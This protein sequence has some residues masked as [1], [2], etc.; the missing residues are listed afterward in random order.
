MRRL[1][2]FI[3]G[4]LLA[5]L[6][7]W[8]L[9]Y[10]MGWLMRP[11]LSESVAP[12]SPEE[13]KAAEENRR[14]RIDPQRPLVLWRDVD[15]SQ[16]PSAPWYPKGEAPVLRELVAEGKLPPVHERVGP[17][18]LVLAGV[19]GIGRYGG[20]W[21]RVA[22]ADGD[23]S[24]VTS[25]IAYPNLVRWSPQGYP[26]VPHIAKSFEAS[27]DK[28][29]YVFTLRRGM[30]WSDG[31]PFTTDDIMYWWQCEATYKP[32]RTVPPTIMKVRGELGQIEKIDQYRFRVK[33]PHPNGLFLA[34]LAT[35]A[36]AEFTNS[37]AHYLRQYHPDFGDQALIEKTMA[38]LKLQTKRA[39][40][41]A[42]R[43]WQNPEH[44]RLWPWL[45]RTYKPNPPHTLVRNPYYF[46]V[47]SEGNQLP[48]VDRLLFEVKTPELIS[49]SA[50]N[51]EITMQ[52]RHIRYS[53]YTLLMSNRRAGGYEVLHWYSGDRSA[54]VI[55]PNLQRKVDPD[56]PS[57]AKKRQLLNMKEFRQALSL[58]ID[59]PSLILAEYNGQ[60]E[61]SQVAPGPESPFHEP[62][63]YTAYTAY[64]PDRAN[65]LLDS[66][67]LSRRDYEG[68]RT[69]PDGTRMQFYI[70]CTSFTGAQ[71]AQAVAEDW[72]KVGIRCAVRERARPLYT[73]YVEAL[74]HDFCV[75]MS[76]GEFMPLLE[77]R[78]YVPVLGSEYARGFAKWYLW[79]G[80]YGDPAARNPGA[81]EP[82]V[83]HPLRR[84][85]EIYE[86]AIAAP[87]LEKQVE[88]FREAMK[89]AAENVWTINICTAPPTLVIVKNGFRNVPRH[90]VYSW[91]FQS[92]GN[93]GVETYFFES[94]SDSP[95]AVAQVKHDVM[96]AT[97]RQA[98][99]T[100]AKPAPSVSRPIWGRII[101]TLIWVAVIAFTGFLAVRHPYIGR[102]L[103]IMVPTLLIISIIAFAIIQLP[104]GDYLTTRIARLQESGD[105]ADLQQIEE[106]KELFHLEDPL[107]KQYLRWSG[108]LWFSTFSEKDL[109]LLQGYMGRSM[110]NSQPVNE[111]V[112]DRILLTVILSLGTVLLTWAIALPIGIYSAVRQYS[113]GDYLATF[114]GFIGMC[115]PNFLL[116]LV[117]MYIASRFFGIKVSGL[118]SSHYGAQ[119]EW[120]WGKF[121]D[122]LQHLWLPL[123]ILAI[124]GTAGMIRVMRNNLLDELK[125]PYVTTARAKGVRPLKL[126][127]KYPVRIALNPFISGI[128]GLFPALVSGGAIVSI[129]MSLPTVGPLM[130]SALLSEDM[131]LAGS[132]LMVLSALGVMGTLVSDLLLLWLDPRI[133]FEG[134]TR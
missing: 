97:P 30:R 69:F 20:T 40:Y 130:V 79:G 115:V 119:P 46:A 86:A 44:P 128:G 99:P 37:P 74:K 124:G 4:A 107:W 14:I 82:P 106:L 133:R 1:W 53:D 17:E 90:A 93:T 131:Y 10:A 2:F 71:P 76:N 32:L 42:V 116:A 31:H 52:A 109:G 123:L 27:E 59:R 108:L 129:V 102:R 94:P 35:V 13:I 113:I 111:I 50:A 104:P 98:L 47:D 125:K 39:V 55:Q 68:Y 101:R 33:F 19:D 58:A 118:F 73:T 48:Y 3:S 51:G 49:V 134:G 96:V 89:I 62:S 61:P 28:R 34:Q 36:G 100:L 45:Y 67:G 127:L 121:V 5:G 84:A 38:L 81:V 9:L 77:P 15:Y 78:M 24:V 105:Q 60:C 80:L 11:E 65:A 112:G 126:L 88:I 63:L 57:T 7:F 66:I 83:D 117:L 16:G 21:I 64:D 29:E 120:T 110:E 22:N 8:A 23:V 25:R 85:M 95:G 132:M 41:G 43:S 114:I 18:P 75:W 70:D 92:P 103:L 87:T 72:A 54:Y 56:D 122:L 91:D 26:I 6:G 12:P